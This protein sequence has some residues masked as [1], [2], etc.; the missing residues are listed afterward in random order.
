MEIPEIDTACFHCQQCAEKYV[1]AF[2]VE[3]D[4][5]FPRY[6][7]L[8]RLLGLCLTVDES[9][10]KIRDNLRRLENYGVIIRYPGLTVPL[11]MAYEAF[12]NAGQ[13]REFVRKKLKIK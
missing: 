2:L 7:D 11:E 3:H 9:F 12:E 5:G 4:V 6:H 8:V 10:E 13:A 1:K